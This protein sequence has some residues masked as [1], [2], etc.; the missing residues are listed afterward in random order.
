LLQF[1]GS[2]QKLEIT[3]FWKDF[4]P[5]ADSKDLLACVWGGGGHEMKT[6]F[7]LTILTLLCC[8]LFAPCSASPQ[9]S[10]VGTEK[11]VATPDGKT[12][13]IESG[14]VAPPT[15]AAPRT[16]T[17]PSGTTE[18]HPGIQASTPETVHHEPTL[19]P[20]KQTTTN[21]T[22]REKSIEQHEAIPQEGSRNL[23]DKTEQFCPVFA[24]VWDGCP[25]ARH[26][27]SSDDSSNRRDSN[28]GPQ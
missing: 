12:A 22:Y 2:F 13:V 14:T 15:G 23:G 21:K 10:G 25:K 19:T 18:T 11:S 9:Q 28:D 4:I 7:C 6:T 24:V 20:E 1:T 27:L 8:L 26:P 5:H 16:A 17:A 3:D